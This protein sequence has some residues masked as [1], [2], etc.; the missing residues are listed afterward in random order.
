[1]KKRSVIFLYLGSIL[2][3]GAYF[4]PLWSITLEAPQYPDGLRLDIW[5]YAIGGSSDDILQNI[6]ILNHYIGMK[7]IEPDAIPELKIF[8]YI[9]GGLIAFGLLSAFLKKKTLVWIWLIAFVIFGIG[10]MYDFYLWEYDYGHDLNLKAP[11]KVPG[12][13]YQPPLFGEKWLLN[14]RAISYPATGAYFMMLSI[15]F[16]ILAIVNEHFWQK[17][18]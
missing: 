10:A 1:M 3:I 5:L 9:V 6:N 14:F 18:S 12:M 8:P 13:V 7:L 16:G 17:N 11:I 4:F 2:L 15:L